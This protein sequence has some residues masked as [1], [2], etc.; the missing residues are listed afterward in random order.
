MVGQIDTLKERE[1]NESRLVRGRQVVWKPDAYS[2]TNALQ[3]QK[4]KGSRG[5]KGSKSSGGSKGYDAALRF[6]FLQP[7]VSWVL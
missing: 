6:L 5:S 2:A 4:L 7:L 1:G 3:L